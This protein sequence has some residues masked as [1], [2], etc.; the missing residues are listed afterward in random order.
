MA[1]Q[2]RLGPSGYPTGVRQSLC[3]QYFRLKIEAIKTGPTFRARPHY[4]FQ[5]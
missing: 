3:R 2:L 5:S 4:R 1:G